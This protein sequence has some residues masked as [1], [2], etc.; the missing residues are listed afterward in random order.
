MEKHTQKII[1]LFSGLK[2]NKLEEFF[3]PFLVVVRACTV[4][5][6]FFV[7]VNFP[8]R[9]SRTQFQFWVFPSP[10]DWGRG[11]CD[12]RVASGLPHRPLFLPA[13]PFKWLEVAS[14]PPL[15]HRLRWTNLRGNSASARTFPLFFRRGSRDKVGS[16]E[17][18]KR[19]N[20]CSAHTRK[21]RCKNGPKQMMSFRLGISPYLGKVKRRF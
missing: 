17:E 18:E 7:V 12:W 13:P 9:L 11:E 1:K 16:N 2:N 20:P 21:K 19:T 6:L 10:S 8:T 4:T 14:S 5:T 15:Q 3:L